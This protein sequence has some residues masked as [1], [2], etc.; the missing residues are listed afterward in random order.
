[1]KKGN[2]KKNVDQAQLKKC[3]SEEIENPS[4]FKIDW[5]RDRVLPFA[6]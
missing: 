2:Y 5:T 1:M 3:T 4:T 6:K